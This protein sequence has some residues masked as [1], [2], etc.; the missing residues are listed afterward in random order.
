MNLP[1]AL[2][3]LSRVQSLYPGRDWKLF[4][5][6]FAPGSVGGAPCAELTRLNVGFDWDDGKLIFDTDVPLTRLSPEDVSAIRKSVKEGQ[7]W[8]AY[9]AYKKQADRIKELEAE[10]A[11]LKAGVV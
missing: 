8:H 10:L 4:A 5:K 3:Q 9:H 2:A 11:L 6:V 1:D 7:S